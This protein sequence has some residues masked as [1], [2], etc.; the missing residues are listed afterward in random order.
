MAIKKS[1]YPKPTN[2]KNIL[3]TGEVSFRVRLMS[4]GHKI[5]KTL[6][7]LSEATTYRDLVNAGAALDEHAERIYLSRAK[8]AESKSFTL[9]NAIKKYRLEKSE[10]KGGWYSEKCRLNKIERC[11]AITTMPLYQIKP[12]HIQDLLEYIRTSGTSAK[13]V[14]PRPTSEATLK[15]YFNLIRHIFQIAVEEWKKIDRNP[16]A[17]IAKS[18][19]P[20]DGQGRDRRL[21]GD[22]YEQMLT[23]LT[24]QA[25]IIFI[26]AVE[27]AMRRGEQ[28]NVRWEHMNLKKRLL[29]IPKTKTDEARTIYLSNT[30][31][32]AFESL[33]Q[34]IKGKIITLTPDAL[35]YQ[36]R[37]ARVAIGAPDLRLHD[38][39]H[40]ATSRLYEKG[41][42]D[43]EAS[44]MTG[45][46]TLTQLKKYAHLK[47]EHMLE[48]LNRPTRST[49]KRFTFN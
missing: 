3:Q 45:H 33:T 10:K 40:E 35:R 9:A 42:G 38:C 4:G 31:I 27:T 17:D 20:K 24:G 11:A 32:T 23:Q 15:R 18:A 43:I 12:E 14:K 28:L 36:W 37:K 19:R 41:M 47:Q 29:L 6:D 2:E 8:K 22:E 7:S 21:R 5:D 34:G 30:A 26:L 46:K 48:K 25:R 39:R 13:G 44:T 49:K 16:V 1:E